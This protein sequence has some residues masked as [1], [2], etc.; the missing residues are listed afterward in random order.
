MAAVLEN[1]QLSVL[2]AVDDHL[3][4]LP[5]LRAQPTAAGKRRDRIALEHALVFAQALID[6]LG[7]GDDRRR[8]RH[9]IEHPPEVGWLRRPC[10]H[11]RDHIP[12]E[13]VPVGLQ[14]VVPIPQCVEGDEAARNF[15]GAPVARRLV[16]I[17][18]AAQTR[19]AELRV[20]VPP[21]ERAMDQ[22]TPTNSSSCSFS[23]K[24]R[25]SRA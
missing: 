20:V 13:G 18:E 21:Y 6:H 5:G 22:P 2:H 17:D 8:A 9:L 23:M 19:D 4:A 25:R 1:P 14:P 15:R 10:E 24:A 3:H 12:Q 16:D 11:H 7:G